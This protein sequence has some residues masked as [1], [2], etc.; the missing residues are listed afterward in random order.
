MRKSIL[1]AAAAAATAFLPVVQ[2][3]AETATTLY[4]HTPSLANADQVARGTATGAGPSMDATAP[5]KAEPSVAANWLGDA[6][7]DT[8]TA[9][10]VWVGAATGT[11]VGDASVTFWATSP[12]MDEVTVSLY[13]DGATVPFAESVV[14][15]EG[16]AQPTAYTATFEDLKQVVAATAT[17]QINTRS[18]TLRDAT[19]NNV[20][21]TPTAIYFDSVDY[22]SSFTF[23]LTGG[24]IV[25]P[26]EPLGD[27]AIF[28]APDEFSRSSNETSLAVNP[29]TNAAMFQIGLGTARVEFD[30][31]VV[32]PV[33][34]WK[35]VA[36]VYQSLTTLDP[37]LHMDRATGRT[38][39][40]QLVGMNSITAYTDD[41]GE[42]WT[43]TQPPTAAPSF[44]HQSTASGPYAGTP[45]TDS[46]YGRAT[47]YCAQGS[48]LAQCARSD[49]GGDTWGDPIGFNF[50]E[51][52]A[53]HGRPMVGE[54]GVVYVPVKD[55]ENS[56]GLFQFGY[57]PV[58]GL[59]A[60][61]DNGETWRLTMTSIPSGESDP[62]I[63]I[64]AANRLYYFGTSE[65]R[66]LV[67]T[68]DDNGKTMSEP[69]DVA[70]SHGLA[71]V[72][73]ASAV[74]GDAGRAAVS[75][76]GTPDVGDDQAPD[77]TGEWHMYVATTVDGG[78][79]WT[80][81]DITPNDPVQRG[82][83][84]LSGTTCSEG[85]NLLDFQH[86]AVDRDGRV[87]VGYADGCVLRACRLAEGK[88]NADARST[89][90]LATIAVQLTGPRLYESTTG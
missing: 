32:P 13:A 21:R 9:Q 31:S 82:M 44:D 40:S 67:S 88:S 64:D 72:Q 2:A 14:P 54:N 42:T 52:T 84:C 24:V 58:Q 43:P 37:M 36:P 22:P 33:A 86:M 10:P 6:N 56:F 18:T 78:V 80:T 77:Y 15:V 59:Y 71:N 55:C 76:Y 23:T 60:S 45:P 61:E 66:A 26:P 50:A 7:V 90:S 83:I 68:S 51:C 53:F 28:P 25:D 8:G 87:L 75:F 69:V 20:G 4:F 39:V 30:H 5:S 48:L 34:T 47:Y 35:N 1:L 46:A 74:A 89:D 85:R 19:L 41:D 63:A 62:A 79:T 65:A 17:V 3:D 27:Y 11:I 29:R 57:K 38:F 12:A 16:A 70:A 49:D 81:V 73:F